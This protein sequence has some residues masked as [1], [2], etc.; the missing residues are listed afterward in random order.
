MHDICIISAFCTGKFLLVHPR[1][2][3]TSVSIQHTHL[4]IIPRS[5]SNQFDLYVDK[6]CC[7][8]LKGW[9]HHW[10]MAQK[11]VAPVLIKRHQSNLPHQWYILCNVSLRTVILHGHRQVFFFFFFF[12]FGGASILYKTLND[13]IASSWY[14]VHIEFQ[15]SQAPT[16]LR[17]CTI[18]RTVRVRPKHCVGLR[19][20][21]V[22]IFAL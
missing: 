16:C 13:Y 4:L 21:M 15:H 19:R 22:K 6:D 18:L 20:Y 12:K 10:T 8:S 11:S 7:G 14:I 3:F 17:P 2:W 1:K 9:Q 5:S